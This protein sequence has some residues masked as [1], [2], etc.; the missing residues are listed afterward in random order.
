MFFMIVLAVIMTIY[1]V[2]I[3]IFLIFQIMYFRR[4]DAETKRIEQETAETNKR[5]RVLL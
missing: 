3:W 1:S 2:A 4:Y 5:Y